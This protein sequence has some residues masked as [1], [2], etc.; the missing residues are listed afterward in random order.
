VTE[1]VRKRGGSALELSKDAFDSVP[2]SV[3]TCLK[4]ESGSLQCILEV[5]SAV[6][7]ED[8]VLDIVFFSQFAEE[9][10]GERCRGRGKEAN[11]KQA[12]SFGVCG[13]VQPELLVVDPNHCFV[14]CDLIRG[15]TRLGL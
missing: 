1:A 4:S 12:V 14:E 6:N 10:L 15:L 8:S 11:V 9:Y 7:E 13:G 3:A 5:L 2:I